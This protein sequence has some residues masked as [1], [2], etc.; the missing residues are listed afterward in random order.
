[1]ENRTNMTFAAGIDL[2]GTFVKLALVSDNGQIHLEDSL[3]IKSGAQ[4]QDV[5]DTIDAAISRIVEYCTGEGNRISGIGIGT[6]GIVCN[7][8][9][10]GGADNLPG[11]EN[12]PL[13]TLFSEK[14]GVPVFVDN[15]A[16]V[17][18]LGETAYGAARGCTDVIFITVGTGIGGAMVINGKLYGGYQN[19]GAEL[20]HIT[21]E[22]NGIDCSCGSRGCLEAYAS[23]SALIRQYA[24]LIGRDPEEVDG[25]YVVEKFKEGEPFA[26]QC[27]QDHTGYLG[28]GIA[29]F[30]NVFAPQKVVIGGGISEAGQFYID[31]IKSEALRYAMPDCAVNTEVVAASLGN[32]AGCLG[33]ASLVFRNI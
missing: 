7:N 4:R 5:L 22:H 14:Y 8:T 3:K 9:V 13:G 31:M 25:R 6:P 26:I 20:G 15:D 27:M 16:N 19:R 1:M 2:G 33:A 29:S 10:M 32:L 24:R 18:G 17:M 21:V 23:T 30:I 28:H 11:W 12:I